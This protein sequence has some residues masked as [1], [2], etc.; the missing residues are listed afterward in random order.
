VIHFNAKVCL[1]KRAKENVTTTAC[2]SS[3]LL[4]P[5]RLLLIQKPNLEQKVH[6]RAIVYE[7]LN[8]TVTITDEMR[9]RRWTEAAVAH[10]KA[11]L[12]KTSLQGPMEIIR[13]HSEDSSFG[14]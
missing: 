5:K 14:T 1:S 12:T 13:N 3:L 4:T 11:L 2:V 9:E 7:G 8:G 10:F 6:V